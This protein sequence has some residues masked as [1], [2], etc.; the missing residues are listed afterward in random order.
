MATSFQYFPPP[1][2]CRHGEQRSWSCTGA[3][4]AGQAPSTSRSAASG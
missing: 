1:Q 2:I 3:T 4:W